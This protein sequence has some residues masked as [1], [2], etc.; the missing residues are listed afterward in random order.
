MFLSKDFEF[1]ASEIAN[2]TNSILVG[3]DIK[4]NNI[5]RLGEQVDG[6][7][8]LC[9]P[10][11][12]KSLEE[13][14]E[15]CLVFCTE[16]TV[17]NK[18]NLS[19][20]VCDNPKFEYFDFLNNYVVTETSYWVQ[21]IVSVS[22]KKY[23]EVNFGYN[24]KIG[25]NSIIAPGT[26]IGSNV[27]I[28]SNVVIRSNVEIGDDVII[29]DNTVIGSE[30]FGFVVSGDKTIHV[31]QLGN[32]IIGNEVVIGS[33]C[34]VESPALGATIIHN[35]VKIDD[36]VQIGHNQEIGEYTMIAAGFKGIGGCVI[37]KN[38]FIGMGVTI[39]SKKAKIGDH[40]FI[41]AGTVLTK[42]VPNNKTVYSKTELVFVDNT[43][44]EEM[45]STPKSK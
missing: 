30:G 27:I 21:D 24:V 3:D 35:H 40:C 41:G 15:K 2:M 22:S 45:L 26:R 10:K 42:E 44:M 6:A 36:L 38:C 31:P 11:F 1:D 17:I 34:A 14:D 16:D 33:S 4:V 13:I 19:F 39:V 29:K 9:Y 12:R 37:G 5:K 7:M 25:Q 23:P 20:I 32:I 18:E 28:G 8:I 43:Q